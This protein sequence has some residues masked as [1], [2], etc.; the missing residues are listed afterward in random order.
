M[1]PNSSWKMVLKLTGAQN[2]WWAPRVL[3]DVSQNSQAWGKHEITE[4]EMHSLS[5]LIQ[6]FP[7]QSSTLQL[8]LSHLPIAPVPKV[9]ILQ[10]NTIKKQRKKSNLHAWF[11]TIFCLL[12]IDDFRWLNGKYSTHIFEYLNKCRVR[13]YPPKWMRVVCLRLVN[14]N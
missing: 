5:K 14:A 1:Q 11:Q 10:D 6:H 9:P 8:I 13:K 4:E 2:W 3:K 7:L 12:W